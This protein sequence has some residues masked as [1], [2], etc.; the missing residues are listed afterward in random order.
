MDPFSILRSLSLMRSGNRLRRERAAGKSSRRLSLEQLEDR[1]LPSCND[2]SG[3]VFNDLNNNGLM[4]PGEIGLA[5]S[6]IQL[7]NASGAVIATALTD[8]NGFYQFSVDNTIDTTPTTLTRTATIAAAPTDFIRTVSIQ[9][10]DPSLGTLTS[11]DIINGGTFVSRIQVESLDSAPS[12]ITGTVSGSLQ[13]T[14]PGILGTGLVTTGS[15]N[16]TFNA[17]A[18]DGAIDFGGTSGHDFGPQSAFGSQAATVTDASD[19][20]AFT[21]TG[22]VTFNEAAHATSSAGG[23]GNV[24]THITSSASGT[25]S[26]VYHYIPSNC[27]RPGAYTIVQATE[28]GG[29]LDGKESSGG[30]VIPNSVG[31]HLIHVTLTD[32]DSTQNDFAEILPASV[33]GFVYVDNNDNGVKEAGEAGLA[34]VSIT[35]SGANDL[36]PVSVAAQTAPD[37]SYSFS[38]LRPGTYVVS[39]TS[40]PAGFLKGKI[41]VGSAGGSLGIDQISAVNLNPGISGVHYDFG[42]L[43]PSSLSGFVYFDH[44]G[45]GLFDSGESGIAGVLITLLGDDD[46]GQPV[47]AQERTGPDGSYQFTGLR[48]GSYIIIKTPPAHYQDGHQN[49]GSVGGIAGQEF[50]AQISLAM[51]MAGVHYD[52]G[53]VLPPTPPPPPPQLQVLF[54]FPCQMPNP[55]VPTVILNKDQLVEYSQGHPDPVTTSNVWFIDGLYRDLLNRQSDIGGLTGFAMELYNGA[56]RAQIAQIIW[57]SAE[58][59][60]IE[61]DQLYAMIL[62]RAADPAGR[63]GWVQAMLNGMTELD[64]ARQLILSSEYQNGRADNASFV[65][66]VYGD[67]L[68]RFP[69]ADEVA[70]WSQSLSNGLGRGAFADAILH[71]LEFNQNFLVP[72]FYE[73]LLCRTPQSVASDPGVANWAQFLS[74]SGGPLALENFAEALLASDEFY[75][76]GTMAAVHAGV[77][78]HN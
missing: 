28:P 15:S 55:P 77:L 49:L 2:I 48:P 46:L 75:A 73:Q 71:S 3:F 1:F 63:A 20:A 38:N 14:G 32:S 24:V 57:R 67:V 60:G 51:G 54:V 62:H 17:T 64:V 45:N 13:L 9:Q 52:F 21:G 27:L 58:H 34:G 61:V 40:Q 33:S 74:F 19:L 69:T 68:G 36:G 6:T 72:M 53:E 70:N 16:E 22:I 12:I 50:F 37:G 25:V 35:L 4:D 8:A 42:E 66:A 44:N 30:V 5:N 31:L 41:S 39:K 65:N 10:F 56:S 76:M 47:S 11:I 29:Y 59:R 43:Q 78:P 18:F 7:R 23:A 26:V